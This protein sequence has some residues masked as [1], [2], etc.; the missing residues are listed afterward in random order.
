MMWLKI[1][2]VIPSAIPNILDVT[3]IALIIFPGKPISEIVQDP[4]VSP[5]SRFFRT[6]NQALIVT[7]QVVEV[8]TDWYGIHSC[9]EENGNV[10]LT[11]H[12]EYFIKWPIRGSSAIF[13]PPNEKDALLLNQLGDTLLAGVQAI[14]TATRAVEQQL[15][16]FVS[17]DYPKVFGIHLRLQKSG[18]AI[19][20]TSPT[21]KQLPAIKFAPQPGAV[22]I[23]GGK[24]ICAV[25][26][27]AASSDIKEDLVAMLKELIPSEDRSPAWGGI[28]GVPAEAE[29][30]Q[31]NQGSAVSESD[32]A[33]T[34]A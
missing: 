16:N 20:V 5:F 34:G 26:L 6:E 2:M 14:L 30:P 19:T 29:S 27:E 33:P 15:A 17:N 7:E 23:L 13:V 31:G 28:M 10:L 4:H 1:D 18:E 24:E 8:P 22:L 12:G 3:D 25:S 21:H 32:T 11:Q 9:P